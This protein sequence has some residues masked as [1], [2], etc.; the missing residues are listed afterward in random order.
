[1]SKEHCQHEER[2]DRVVSTRDHTDRRGGQG[3]GSNEA[4][5]RAEGSSDEVIE[6]GH[7]GNARERFWQQDAETRE[8][9]ELRT[10]NLDPESERRLVHRHEA[11]RVKGDQEEVPPGL[12]H[13]EHGGW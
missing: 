6:D 7:G 1:D 4:W 11:T 5:D 2:I 10:R 13:A 12:H 9:D 3:E 8:S